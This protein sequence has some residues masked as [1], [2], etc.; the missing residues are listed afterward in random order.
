MWLLVRRFAF[1]ACPW[2]IDHSK[3]CF[4]RQSLQ[5]STL[6]QFHT[7]TFV[8]DFKTPYTNTIY[9]L[10]FWIM[11]L[12][13]NQNVVKGNSLL[14]P[15]STTTRNRNYIKPMLKLCKCQKDWRAKEKIYDSIMPSV[16]IQNLR[17]LSNV[18]LWGCK[19][20]GKA[21]NITVTFKR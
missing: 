18:L 20:C 15:C 7:E 9:T 17:A 19:N 16:L 14:R 3:K 10:T 4:V 8:G 5:V 1:S 6:S 2:P 13:F 12:V 21:I 11:Q